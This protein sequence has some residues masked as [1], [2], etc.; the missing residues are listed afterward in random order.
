[1]K[2]EIVNIFKMIDK[3]DTIDREI[4]RDA[5][6]RC[7][8]LMQKIA[9]QYFLPTN[10]VIAAFCA[11][12]PN[13]DYVGNLRSLISVIEYRE[14]A[15]VSTYKRCAMR[16]IMYL[17]GERFDTQSRGLKTKSFYLNICNPLDP[18]PITIDGHMCAIW[19]D[20]ANAIMKDFSISKTKYLE[21]AEDFKTVARWLNILPN[22]LQATLW[23]TR[24]RTL[25]IAF[26][27]TTPMFQDPGRITFSIDE[28]KPYEVSIPL[29][30]SSVPSSNNIK[31]TSLRLQTTSKM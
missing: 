31:Q 12:S 19:H 26:N 16:A 30:S 21:I 9:A 13:N 14:N 29:P 6:S 15:T 18:D 5:Y 4:G 1:M 11:L 17:N 28:L 8:A 3:A 22:Q 7:N 23:H 27:P 24:K 2:A 20:K 10:N 25:G